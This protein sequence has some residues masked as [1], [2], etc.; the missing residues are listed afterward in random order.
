[1]SYQLSFHEVSIE[2][3]IRSALHAYKDHLIKNITQSI[4]TNELV[5]AE[6]E[7]KR[8]V[9]TIRA[10][11][12]ISNQKGKGRYKI[13]GTYT[14]PNADVAEAVL[15]SLSFKVNQNLVD[16]EYKTVLTYVEEN[17]FCVPDEAKE[18]IQAG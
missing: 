14:F 17:L 11:Y 9:S 15:S 6:I 10:L 5:S 1:M 8:L 3:L 2:F 18:T 12:C 16:N 4:D 7:A 13:E